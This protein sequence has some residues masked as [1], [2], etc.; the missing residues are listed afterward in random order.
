MDPA[1]I[2]ALVSGALS[3]TE[4]LLPQ[5]QALQTSG[6]ITADQQAAVLARYN[7][8]KAAADGQFAGPEWQLAPPPAPAPGI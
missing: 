6:Q 2:L 7:S 1:T 3:L 8:L 4:Q 5:L